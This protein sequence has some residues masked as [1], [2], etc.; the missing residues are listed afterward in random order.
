M[1]TPLVQIIIPVY[2]AQQYLR[3]CL[4]SVKNQSFTDWQAFLIDDASTD[5]SREIIRSYA[6][7]D[8]RF[9]PVF[10]DENGGVSRSRN[11]GL[12]M[13]SARYAA[14]LD[15]DDFWELDM[16]QTLVRTAQEQ[17]CDVVQCRFIYDF[18]GGK[19]VLP[20]GAF[21]RDVL[22]EGRGLRRVYLR[23]MTGINM[24][25]VCMKLVKTR[26]FSGL[27]FDVRMKTAEDLMMCIQIFKRVK[28]YGFVNQPMYHY[29]RSETSITGR[30]LSGVE[31]MRCNREISREL[32][33][34]LPLWGIDRFGYRGLSWLRPYTI[35]CSKIFRMLREKLMSRS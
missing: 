11:R 2:N 29:R 4:D 3:Q 24:N 13:L 14:F 32:I 8:E 22:L 10:R 1:S 6:G 30:G 17:D 5:G 27:S 35:T 25:H 26:L 31:K 34:A 12:E 9:V 33:R 15:S 18:P 28:R 20:A 21:R 19:T 16:L 23:M 7:E